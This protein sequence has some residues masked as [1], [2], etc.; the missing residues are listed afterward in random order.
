MGRF[1]CSSAML[2]AC[3]FPV[4]EGLNAD[5]HVL[6]VKQVGEGDGFEFNAV[7]QSLV[8]GGTH[9]LFSNP[10]SVG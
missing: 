1:S 5:F 9:G 10:E 3:G 7:G 8:E 4:E 2:P 6:A